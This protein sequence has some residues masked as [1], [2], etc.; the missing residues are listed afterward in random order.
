MGNVLKKK[1]KKK[2]RKTR[3]NND[4]AKILTCRFYNKN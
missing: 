1:N 2:K 4:A 3:Q